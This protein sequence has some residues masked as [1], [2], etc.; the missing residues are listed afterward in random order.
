MTTTR[1]CP[2]CGTVLE[3]YDHEGIELDRCPAGCGLWF[4]R[5]ELPLVV[6]SEQQPREE[7][8]R[9]SAAD[10]AARD[11]GASVVA[12]IASDRRPCAVC[13]AAMRLTEYAASGIAI[14][15]CA[16]KHGIWLDAGELEQI[17]AY[18]E[19]MR[20]QGTPEDAEI[21]VRG[22]PIPPEVLAGI[23]AASVPVP[24]PPPK[25]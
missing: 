16:S 17:E 23:S 22:V 10:H 6:H 24:P 14:D 25:S 15:E 19:A 20:R 7:A 21:Q 2:N 13:G 8:E 9:M 3:P 12:E 5:G 18:A 1:T 4:D 11:A